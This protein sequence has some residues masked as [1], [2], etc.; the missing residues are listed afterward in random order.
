LPR[1]P[2]GFGQ[3][4]SLGNGRGNLLPNNLDRTLVFTQTEKDRLA[5]S[6]IPRAPVQTD[7]TKIQDYR[8]D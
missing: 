4:A 7:L 2:E 5:Q 1:S 6:I 3:K 8:N